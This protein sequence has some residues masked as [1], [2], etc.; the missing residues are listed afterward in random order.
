ME[1]KG[2]KDLGELEKEVEGVG[3]E[4]RGEGEGVWKKR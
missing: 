2:V 4:L 3:V 1:R